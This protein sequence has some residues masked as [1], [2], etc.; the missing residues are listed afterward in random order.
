MEEERLVLLDE[1][2]HSHNLDNSFQTAELDMDQDNDLTFLSQST[3]HV[4]DDSVLEEQ[5]RFEEEAEELR[6]LTESFSSNSTPTRSKNTSLKIKVMEDSGSHAGSK[7]DTTAISPNTQRTVE[8]GV[9]LNSPTSDGKISTSGQ[10]PPTP[11]E[12]AQCGCCVIS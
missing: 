1:S 9:S 3:V 2:D 8:D 12:P 7:S 11:E 6:M 4:D 5:A 10:H